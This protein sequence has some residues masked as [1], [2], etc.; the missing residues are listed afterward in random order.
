MQMMAAFEAASAI[1]GVAELPRFAQK[2]QSYLCSLQLTAKLRV[3]VRAFW[4][5]LGNAA[6]VRHDQIWPEDIVFVT[7]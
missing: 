6:A 2:L 5:G 3:E 7:C 1:F 4:T